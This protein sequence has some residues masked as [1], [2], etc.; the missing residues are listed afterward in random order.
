MRNG[1]IN[2]MSKQLQDRAYFISFCIEQYKTAKGL[3]GCE[4]AQYFAEHHVLDYLYDH[5]N[6]LHT[7]GHRWLVG[8]IDDFIRRKEG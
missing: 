7:Q 2:P 8:E 5:F 4:V 6:V 3:S 1:I